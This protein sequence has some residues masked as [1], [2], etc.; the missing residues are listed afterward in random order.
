MLQL[1][2]RREKPGPPVPAMPLPPPPPP[3]SGESLMPDATQPV[4]PERLEA[5][6]VAVNAAY[7]PRATGRAA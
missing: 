2:P 5:A 1:Q 4:D 3:T 7:R 6:L